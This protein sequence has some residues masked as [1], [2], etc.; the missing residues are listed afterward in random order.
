SARPVTSP[1]TLRWHGCY[2]RRRPAGG[3]EALKTDAWL[4]AR[5]TGPLFHRD[6]RPKTPALDFK[7]GAKASRC[8]FNLSMCR[9]LS[10]QPEEA[11]EHVAVRR[12]CELVQPVA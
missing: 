4:R 12:S 11:A 5:R 2:H 6:F 7:K 8:C 10:A 9:S 3:H 1:P